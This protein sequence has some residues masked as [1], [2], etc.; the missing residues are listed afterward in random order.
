MAGYRA[1]FDASIADP[2]RFWADAARAVTWTRE[3]EKIL[4]DSNPPFYRWFADGELNTCANALDRHVD[5]G[6]GDQPALIYDSPVTGSQRTFT[7]REL[8]DATAKFAGGL[9]GLGVAKGD[10]VVIYMPMIPEAVI[11][12]LACAR[13]GAI[14]S[15]VFGGFAA[16][17]LAVRIDDARP[18]VVISASCGIEPSRTVAYK[19]MLDAALE[20]SEHP[21]RTCVIAQRDRQ[22]CELAPDRDLD[23]EDVA[24]AAPVDPVP[25]A[26]TDPLYVLYTSGT[27]GKPKGIVRDNGGHA[28]ALLWSMRNIYDIAPGEV[29]WA[30]SDVGWVVGHSYIVYGPLLLGAT[31]VLYEGKPVG[32]PDPG[33][34]WRVASEHGVKALFTAPTAVRAIRKEDPDGS[35]I[36]RYDLS[37]MEY[38]FQ[39]GERLD[40]DTYEWAAQKLGIPVVDH[41]WQT[42]T[43]WAIAANPMGLDPLP[44]KPGSPT[45]PMPGYNVEILNADGSPCAANEE[46][47]ICIRLP[48]PPGTLTTLWGDDDRYRASYLSEHPGYYL[49]GDGG[50]LDEDGYLFV[51]GR[52][53][54]VI[55]VAGHRLSTGSIEAVLATHPAV[56]ECAVIGVRDDIKGQVPR[57]FVVLKSGASTEGLAEQLIESVRENIGAVASFKLVDVVPALPKTRSGKILRKTMRGIAHGRDEPL[58]STIEDPAV[59]ETLKPILKN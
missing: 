47:D 30:A 21:P 44:I 2:E 14:H 4:D 28:V 20:M 46:G 33:A 15:V 36:G 23:W 51:M 43:G 1:L 29:F 7:Y 10:R 56:A 57:G 9:R 35:H 38:L 42:E 52:I 40:P 32:T 49:T 31:T 16:H 24:V 26:A 54:D 12:M 37:R 19:P 45:V 41:W 59:I 3:P 58:P 48:L 27:T 50:Y 17:E 22:R 11:A 6:R 8:R 25:V 39:A 5:D 18:K 13:L 53:D 55:N 34:F